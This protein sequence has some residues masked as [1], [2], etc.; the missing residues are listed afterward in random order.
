[1]E[2]REFRQTY[3][4]LNERPCVFEKAILLNRGG[5]SRCRRVYL[6]EREG[7]ACMSLADHLQCAAVSEALHHNA[8]FALRLP[9]GDE[10]LPH[11]KEV[12]VQCGGLLGLQQA[13]DP[14]A[15]AEYVA[16]I[17]Q[18]L[19]QALARHGDLEQLPYQQAVRRIVHYQARRRHAKP[20]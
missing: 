8:R 14:E 6:A 19:S 9:K 7:A 11:A 20:S 15:A 4:E 2:E 5:C 3:H 18:L 12:K 17:H 10:T 16:D 1:M 13:L